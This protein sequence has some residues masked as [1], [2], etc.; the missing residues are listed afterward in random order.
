LGFWV[1]Q[2]VVLVLAVHADQPAGQLAQLARRRGPAVDA[3]LPAAPDLARQDRLPALALE[4]GV[5]HRALGA[6]ADLVGAGPSAQRQ[7]QGV[8]DQR[9]AAAGLAG[10]EVETGPE[11]DAGALDQ[12]QVADVELLQRGRFSSG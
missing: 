8:D 5:D 11:V 7:A 2:G 12:R 1:Q 3:G 9:L 10:Q 4:G 6:V